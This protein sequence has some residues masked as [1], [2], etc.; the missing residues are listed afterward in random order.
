[1]IKRIITVFLICL[2][3]A[4]SAN[5]INEQLL[6]QKLRFSL[7]AIYGF[8]AI[9]TFIIYFLIN[10]VYKNL[11]NQAGYAYLISVF[12]KMGVFVLVFKT[13][14]FSIDALTKPEKITLIVPLFLFLFLE[15]IFITKLLNLKE[16]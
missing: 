13:S 10:L 16:D 3:I 6:T 14:V 2:V 11:P 7:N 8:H 12:I 1:M 5:I 4:V 9:A 15:A